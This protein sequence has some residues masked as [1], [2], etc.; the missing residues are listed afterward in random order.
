MKSENDLIQRLENHRTPPPDGFVERVMESLPT[1]RMQRSAG[2]WPRQGR[3]IAPA[4]AGA[5]V[6][7][8]AVFAVGHRAGPVETA[9]VNFHFELHAPGADKV[10]L[11]GTFNNWMT[12][13]IVLVG[14]DASGHWTA[15]VELPEGRHEYIFLVDG[16]RWLADPKAATHR[17]DGFGRVNTV[18]NI[19]EENNA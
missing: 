11:L 8:L 5:A 3:W 1:W 19:Y 6:A 10:E 18:I 16:E 9:A 2:F 12:D 14:P 15:T 13:D 7:L 17:P 4:L